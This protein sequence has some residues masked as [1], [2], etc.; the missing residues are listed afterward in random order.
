M[1]A[2]ISTVKVALGESPQ[3][4]QWAQKIAARIKEAYPGWKMH[5]LRPVCG[6]HDAE[7]LFVSLGPSLAEFEQKQK[8]QHE[9]EKWQALVKE[10]RESH[11]KV[12]LSR[13]IYTVVE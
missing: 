8:K 4:F 3:A 7:I 12:R 2:E 9:D 6:D 13:E 5:V 1:V 11:W 10:F